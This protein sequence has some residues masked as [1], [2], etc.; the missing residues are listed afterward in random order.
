MESKQSLLRDVCTRTPELA[1]LIIDNL[2]KLTK[3][4]DVLAIEASD[5]A[6]TFHLG[7]KQDHE[8]TKY[9]IDVTDDE[10]T[11]AKDDQ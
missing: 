6:V 5:S 11:E 4:Y 9:V 3:Q 1:Q 10:K 2:E 8:V 7:S